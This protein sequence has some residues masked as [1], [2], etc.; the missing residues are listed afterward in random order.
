MDFFAECLAKL[1]AAG[2]EAP[3]LET[4]LLWAAVLHCAASEV[5]ADIALT[6]AQ[7]VAIAALVARRLAHEPLDKIV[8]HREFYKADFKVSTDVL[9]PRPDSETLV[10]SA[11]ALPLA[12]SARILDLGTGSGCLLISLLA[13]RPQARGT[14]VDISP[15]AL[16]IAREN[17]AT[18]GVT[19]Q[20]KFVCADWFEH[21]FSTK[22]GGP[23]ALII[24][25]P[26]YI[27]SAEIATLAPEVKNYDPRL[28]LDGG[29]DGLQSYRR[30]AELAPQLL[31]DGGYI[32]LEAGYGQAADIA[33]LF[34][35]QGLQ[36]CA[37]R[38][39][40]GG[41]DRCIILQKLV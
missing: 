29:V 26:P 5:Y 20:I 12:A 13:E 8:G 39:D 34:V 17:A 7:K 25:N 37:I 41:V 36:M 11:L 28:A 19:K 22:I 10:E 31:E 27:P 24:S 35:A 4:R 6:A 33:A 9:S 16:Q 40:L 15:A 23:F 3:R 38:K 1:Q 18:V 21:D 30:L 2:I 14:A 32:V